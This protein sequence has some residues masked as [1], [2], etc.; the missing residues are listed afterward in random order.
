[1]KGFPYRVRHTPIGGN[2]WYVYVKTLLM[3]ESVLRILAGYDA[4]LSSLGRPGVGSQ[5][6]EESRGEEWVPVEGFVERA[7]SDSRTT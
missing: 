3:A 1:M 7:F 4:H 6:V 5:E 2:P